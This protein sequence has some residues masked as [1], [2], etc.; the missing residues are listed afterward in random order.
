MLAHASAVLQKIDKVLT[1]SVCCRQPKLW[2]MR[3]SASLAAAW[4]GLP[5]DPLAGL[6]TGMVDE[7][8]GRAACGGIHM[9]APSLLGATLATNLLSFGGI[10]ISF[11]SQ[12]LSG[13]LRKSRTLP[14]FSTKYLKCL[15]TQGTT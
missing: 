4:T 13:R 3:E 1:Y 5:V 7:P 11:F 14:P 10:R 2:A 9:I 8:C 6:S 12:Q 15:K